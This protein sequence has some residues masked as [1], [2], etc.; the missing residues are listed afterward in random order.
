MSEGT[1]AL[2]VDQVPR[3][4]PA[5]RPVWYVPFNDEYRVKSEANRRKV[6]SERACEV[7]RRSTFVHYFTASQVCNVPCLPSPHARSK[8]NHHT[9]QTR[10]RTRHLRAAHGTL[11]IRGQLMAAGCRRFTA[12]S[13]GSRRASVSSHS[14][15]SSCAPSTPNASGEDTHRSAS[16]HRL[17]MTHTALQAPTD[18]T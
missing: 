6:G 16:P 15:S 9:H 3:V 8:S 4:E 2:F 7:L 10:S 12:S 13:I 14:S 11:V 5:D 17:H 18:C 1:P